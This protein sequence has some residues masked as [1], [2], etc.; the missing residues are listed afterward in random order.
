M[1]EMNTEDLRYQVK[2]SSYR[3][4]VHL[5]S[6]NSGARHS[7]VVSLVPTMSVLLR[8]VF[9]EY[10]SATQVQLIKT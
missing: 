9:E 3:T 1:D 5:L 6:H 10:K 4:Q 7:V 8:L 2:S